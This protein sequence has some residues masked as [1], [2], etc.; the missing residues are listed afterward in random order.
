MKPSPAFY[1][2][3][4]KLEL[5]TTN[6]YPR[7]WPKNP[8]LIRNPLH[9]QIKTQ[10]YA[11]ILKK[12]LLLPNTNEFKNQKNF[13]DQFLRKCPQNLTLTLNLLLSLIISKIPPCHFCTLVVPQ[14]HEPIEK[15]YS[16]MDRQMCA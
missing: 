1:Q 12:S 10:T 2:K 6:Q 9:S 8:F 13:N 3:A 15:N 4:K 11:I 14:L 7:K 5:S 16:K